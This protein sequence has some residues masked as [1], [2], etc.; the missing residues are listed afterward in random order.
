MVETNAIVKAGPLEIRPLK[1][2]DFKC[3]RFLDPHCIVM[4]KIL[5]WSSV[6]IIESYPDIQR[7]FIY[8]PDSG[9]DFETMSGY[10]MPHPFLIPETLTGI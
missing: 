6:R 4:I 7:S 5:D 3:F 8:L 9:P 10:Q 1:N 2:L